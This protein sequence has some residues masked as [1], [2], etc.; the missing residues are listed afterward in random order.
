[1]MTP[2]LDFLAEPA[3]VLD[4]A[5]TVIS[6]NAGARRRLGR[7]PAG[8]TLPEIAVGDRR[9]LAR[10]LR[11]ASRSTSP[12]VGTLSLAGADGLQRY[13]VHAARLGGPQEGAPRLVLRFLPSDEDQFVLLTRRVRELDVQLRQRLQEKAALQE[14]LLRN[15]TLLEELQHRVKNNIQMMMT[16]VK[17]SAKGRDGPHLAE[18]VETAHLRLRAMATTQDAIYRANKHGAVSSGAF[19]KDLVAG[20]GEAAGFAD[21]IEADIEDLDLCNEQAHCVALIVNELVT[22]A[23]KY[24]LDRGEGRIRVGFRRDGDDHELVVADDGP[25]LP[26]GAGTRYSGL[27]IVRGLCRQIGGRLD[28]E[29]DDGTT[30]RIRFAARDGGT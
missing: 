30:C 26:A 11:Q 27:Q 19:L 3:F 18:V 7:D 6:A 9:E 28:I 20:I 8:E 23:G 1:M 15:Q 4:L 17:M 14:A 21:A 16:L 2:A 29:T 12:A 22:N 13:R 10:F 5:G 24:A 25:G